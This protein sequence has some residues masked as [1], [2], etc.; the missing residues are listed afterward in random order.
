[1]KFAN[2]NQETERQIINV[3]LD[4]FAYTA[5]PEEPLILCGY[6]FELIDETKTS[7]FVRLYQITTIFEGDDNKQLEWTRWKL[8]VVYELNTTS[9]LIKYSDA[10]RLPSE[11]IAPDM[12]VVYEKLN[13]PERCYETAI[14][15]Y[16]NHSENE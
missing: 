16:N 9:G 10:Y 13:D 14:N 3:Y 5:E 15:W 7:Q 12:S 1:M 11:Q 2:L 6:E 4:D 8:D